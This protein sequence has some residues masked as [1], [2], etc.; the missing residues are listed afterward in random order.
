M[1]YVVVQLP[2]A[3]ETL[4]Y[5]VDV[6][7]LDERALAAALSAGLASLERAGAGAVR[8]TAIDG[9]WSGV[10]QRSGFLAPKADNHLRVIV[11]ENDPAHPLCRAAADLSRWYLTDGD[12]DDETMG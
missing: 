10:L 1:G 4:G 9:S 3:G 8:A 7:A 5:L 12:R 2:R 6:L 11:W